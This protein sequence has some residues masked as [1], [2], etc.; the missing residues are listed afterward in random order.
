METSPTTGKI[1]ESLSKAQSQMKNAAFD[2]VNPHFR[3]P[4]ASLA[5]IMDSCRP[6]LSSNGIAILQGTSIDPETLRVNVTTLLT[7]VSGEWIK[8]VISIKPAA[9][10]AQAIGSAASYGRRYGLSALV[11]IV[12]EEDD[13]GNLATGRP[14]VKPVLTSVK[15][16][17]ASATAVNPVATKTTAQAEQP[18]TTS[19][20]VTALANAEPAQPCA[21]KPESI[22]SAIPAPMPQ[23]GRIAKIRQVFTL[24][25]QLGQSVDQM[26]SMVGDL[27]ELGSPIRESSQI[28]SD[29]LD[30]IIYALQKALIDKNNSQ[31]EAA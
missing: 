18:N 3:S 4:Y 27:L 23:N 17:S 15:K 6:A 30:M 19:E 2:M 31:K 25:G 24:S 12:S 13:D 8:S 11:S 1:S 14:D 22:K 28:P 29:K 9:D 5:A 20:V 16:T 21:T 26:K 7:H 10:T